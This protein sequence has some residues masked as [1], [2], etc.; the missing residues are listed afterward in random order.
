[1]AINISITLDGVGTIN[2]RINK[3]S[4]SI[5]DISPS[6][7][8]IAQ[9]FRETEG[10]VFSG[11]GAY[12]SRPG[13]IPL[14]PLYKEWKSRHYPGKPILQVTGDLRNSLA[15]KGKNHVEIITNKSLTIGSSDPKMKW[16][17]K[18]T[19][20]M[21]SRPPVTYTRYQGN[22]WAKIIRDDILGSVKK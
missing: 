15:E 17:Q 11:Q 9:D 7:K 19:K 20:K 10:K 16:H 1:M 12:G 22:K 14:A 2:K 13:W 6:F 21:P 5:K 18:G 8:K 4:K 3:V